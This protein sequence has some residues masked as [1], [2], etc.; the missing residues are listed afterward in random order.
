MANLLNEPPNPCTTPSVMSL[1]KRIAVHPLNVLSL[2]SISSFVAA[3]MRPL[4]LHEGDDHGI[5]LGMMVASVHVLS[6]LWWQLN[7]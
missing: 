5:S 6:R 4:S 3:A 2:H 1:L 7:P